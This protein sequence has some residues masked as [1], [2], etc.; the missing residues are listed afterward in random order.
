[1]FK[2]FHRL[3]RENTLL[4]EKLLAYPGKYDSHLQTYLL[5]LVQLFTVLT[6]H[7]QLYPLQLIHA[8]YVQKIAQEELDRVVGTYSRPGFLTVYEGYFIPKGTT[9]QCGPWGI[10]D[11]KNGSTDSFAFRS[12]C[13]LENDCPP[14]DPNTIAFGWG[15]KLSIPPSWDRKCQEAA[16]QVFGGVQLDVSGVT[17]HVRC[18]QGSLG[19]GR[20]TDADVCISAPCNE[21]GGRPISAIDGPGELGLSGTGAR[22]VKR[23][24]DTIDG[25][26]RRRRLMKPLALM[27]EGFSSAGNISSSA[28]GDTGESG[29]IGEDACNAAGKEGGEGKA[30]AH[31]SRSSW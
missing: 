8:P 11:A 23:P 26:P 4:L 9:T 15:R 25:R 7:V 3:E 31:E 17:A 10:S 30:A 21:L 20:E 13:F 2:F 29:N 6:V 14:P 1:M 5:G 24:R 19:V 22:V 16:V 18:I 27:G 28:A 12:E